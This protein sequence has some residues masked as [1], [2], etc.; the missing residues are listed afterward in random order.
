[1][2]TNPSM[3]SLPLLWHFGL[4]DHQRIY[5][6]GVLIKFVSLIMKRIEKCASHF[7]GIDNRSHEADWAVP[8]LLSVGPLGQS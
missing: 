6:L 1:M 2:F 5:A 8:E 4:T 3:I 7:E